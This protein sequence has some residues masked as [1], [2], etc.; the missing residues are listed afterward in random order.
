MV[1]NNILEVPDETTCV[2]EI[3]YI[4]I[5]Q[6]YEHAHEASSIDQSIIICKCIFIH[7]KS[8]EDAL[9]ER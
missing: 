6:N 5:V 2:S 7:F 4:I 9:L 3:G 8:I 1:K